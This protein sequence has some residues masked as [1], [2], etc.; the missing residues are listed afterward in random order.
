LLYA[1]TLFAV[2][3]L[4]FCT[5]MSGSI[6]LASALVLGGIF[7]AY[8]IGLYCRYSDRLAHATF[9]YSVMYLA[10]LFAALLTDHYL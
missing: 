6:Y 1:S 4:P 7:L 10:L 5:R 2:S 9:R 8:A 3:L